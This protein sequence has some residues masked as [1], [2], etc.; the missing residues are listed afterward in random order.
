MNRTL[1]WVGW[2][3]L[4]FVRVARAVVGDFT[5]RPPGWAG[6]LGRR[7]VLS[8]GLLLG[9]VA[10]MAG[11]W[12]GW[13][14][15]SHLPKPVTVGWI[16]NM[17]DAPEPGTEFE[18]QDLTLSF[19]QSV[20]KLESVGKEV[21]P[22]VKMEPKMAGTWTWQQGNSLE[23]EPKES[24][25][26]GTTFRITLSPELFSKHA[27]LETLTKEFHSAPFTVAISQP[28]FYMNPKDPATKQITATLTF[29]HAV[30][31]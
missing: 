10:L 19:D 22:L 18:A 7:P 12:W 30:D 20:A 24:W 8:G 11:G 6:A 31:H 14:W 16:I 17:G 2:P 21:T 27:R 4:L 25:P 26:A 15:Y 23:F 28:T 9:V 13:N 1:A 5:W 3:L 29:S